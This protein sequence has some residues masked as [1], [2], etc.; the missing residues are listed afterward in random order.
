[1]NKEAPLL[2]GFFVAVGEATLTLRV[3]FVLFISD[4][5]LRNTAQNL[6]S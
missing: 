2:R 6:F 3:A 1:V 4:K 5:S